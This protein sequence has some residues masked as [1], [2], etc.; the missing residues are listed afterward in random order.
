V[1]PKGGFVDI[2]RARD[3]TRLS[4][5]VIQNPLTC[6]YDVRG[7][8]GLVWDL[9]VYVDSHPC[10]NCVQLTHN[11]IKNDRRRATVALVHLQGKVKDSS[12]PTFESRQRGLK[13]VKITFAHFIAYLSDTAKCHVAAPEIRPPG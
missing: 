6:P 1:L 13:R 9:S 3:L 7:G 12:G 8:R 11:N 5:G 10:T 2:Q 4:A